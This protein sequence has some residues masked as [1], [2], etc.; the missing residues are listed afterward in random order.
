MASEWFIRVWYRVERSR[1]AVQAS[2]LMLKIVRSWNEAWGKWWVNWDWRMS[3]AKR[4]KRAGRRWVYIL[5]VSLWR[6]VQERKQ[7]CEELETGR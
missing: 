5:S 6:K 1:A 2:R 3:W 4:V 7:W